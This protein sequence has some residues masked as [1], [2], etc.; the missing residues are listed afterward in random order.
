ME[1]T[2]IASNSVIDAP[3]QTAVDTFEIRTSAVP[4]DEG[5]LKS[6]STLDPDRYLR[7]DWC[8]RYRAFGEAVLTA[9][10]LQWQQPQPF[11]QD[12]SIN[13]Y[14]GGMT[15]VFAP[16]SSD[17][18]RL[19]EALTREAVAGLGIESLGCRIGAHQIR[20]L[21]D[22]SHNGFPAPEGFHQDGFDWITIT[23]VAADNVSGAVSILREHPGGPIAHERVMAPGQTAYVDD[24]RLEHYVS[25]FTPKLPG[26]ASRDVVVLTFSAIG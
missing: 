14:A 10:G 20:I 24:R 16:L 15:R 19:V 4:F 11:L 9:A 13:Q 25:P 12:V 1:E 26:Q 17:G 2:T 7:S 22:D 5:M 21:A 6:Y 8:F 23:C 18:L 3:L